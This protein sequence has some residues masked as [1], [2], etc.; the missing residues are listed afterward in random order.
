M[1]FFQAKEDVQKKRIVATTAEVRGLQALAEAEEKV[2][3][4]E[5][6]SRLLAYFEIAM[7]QESFAFR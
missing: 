2:K 7:T 4:R 1:S 6:G 3:V 5:C